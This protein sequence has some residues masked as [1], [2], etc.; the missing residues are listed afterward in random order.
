[1]LYEDN[2][3]AMEN[4]LAGGAA[5]EQSQA[6]V[7]AIW[8]ILAVLQASLWVEWVPSECNP[9]DCFSRPGEADKQREADELADSLHLRGTP[10]RRAPR[11]SLDAA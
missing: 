6:I 2:T 3:P 8:L 10:L 5:D 11:S 9:S 7:A 1:M 4:L